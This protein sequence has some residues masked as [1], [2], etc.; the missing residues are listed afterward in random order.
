MMVTKKPGE[1]AAEAL[2]V[3][4]TGFQRLNG[5]GPANFPRATC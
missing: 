5:E 2:R 4:G 3:S 1:Q